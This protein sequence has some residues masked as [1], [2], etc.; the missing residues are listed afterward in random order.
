MEVLPQGPQMRFLGREP[1]LRLPGGGAQLHPRLW[2]TD[3]P[4]SCIRCVPREKQRR[5]GA[6]TENN[7]GEPNACG[8]K[9]HDN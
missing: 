1:Q 2:E 7:A 6:Q 8:S 9:D 5:R 4:T 3:C